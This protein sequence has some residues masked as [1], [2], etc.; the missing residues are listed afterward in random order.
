M[1]RPVGGLAAVEA[2]AEGV[3]LGNA[4]GEEGAVHRLVLERQAAQSN[5]RGLRVEG[6]S[7]KPTSGV[8]D[9]DHLTALEGWLGGQ[10]PAV[11]PR[12][13]GLPALGAA[14]VDDDVGKAVGAGFWKRPVGLP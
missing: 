2:P 7:E 14:A 13:S 6:L 8:E 12:V 9:A 1:H 4:P 10:V 11:N 3:R 5:L